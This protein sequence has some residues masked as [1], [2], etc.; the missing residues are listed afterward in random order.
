MRNST[1]AFAWLSGCVVSLAACTPVDTNVG[2]NRAGNASTYNESGGEKARGGATNSNGGAIQGGTFNSGGALGKGGTSQAGTSGTVCGPNSRYL[3]PGCAVGDLAPLASPGCYQTCSSAGD[4]SCSA[5]TVCQP[6]VFNPCVCADPA[7]LC[8][9]ACGASTWVCLPKPST[10]D[11]T[12]RNTLILAA[13]N[14]FGECMSP[15]R[16]SL[17]IA[18]NASGSGCDGVSLV[19]GSNMTTEPI[20]TYLGQL[21][22]FGQERARSLALSIANSDGQL[23]SV[24]GC[25]DCADG[26]KTTISLNLNGATTTSAFDYSNGPPQVLADANNYVQSM[27]TALRNCTSNEYVAIT[28]SACTPTH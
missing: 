28:E 8:C 12:Q 10:C 6:R 1:L 16:F 27:I 2:S 26:G 19:I 18:A 15:C 5:G 11:E 20:G 7:E 9:E 13:E 23:Q 25:P 21:T 17:Q 14:T 4:T 24:Y 22:P 3:E